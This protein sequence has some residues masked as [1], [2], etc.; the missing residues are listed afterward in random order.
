MI[1]VTGAAG[2][3]GLAVV[4]ALVAKGEGVRALVRRKEVFHRLRDMGA[5]EVVVGDARDAEFMIGAA[6]GTRAIYH[7]C[8]NMAADEAA[9]GKAVITAAR[10]A[11]V[12]LFA[13]HSVLHPQTDAMPHHWQKLLVERMLIDSG[14]QF[15]ILQPAS[16]MQNVLAEWDSIVTRGIYHVPYSTGTRLGLVDLED[17]AAAAAHVLTE[18]GHEGATYEL[19]GPEVL[20]QDDV[21]RLLGEALGRQVTPEVVPAEDWAHDARAAGLGDYQIDTLQAMFRYYEWGGFWG[22]PRVLGWLLGRPPTTFAQFTLRVSRG[23]RR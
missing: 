20:N 15:V 11:N 2:K 16:Y 4:G 23:Q 3:T 8:P 12:G 19:A 10:H 13:F 5:R 17:V 14:L 1:L 18:R 22:N 7:I 6:A 21:A 9:I